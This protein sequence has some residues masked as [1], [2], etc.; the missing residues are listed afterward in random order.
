MGK[1]IVTISETARQQLTKHYKS[2]DK[3]FIK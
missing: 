3:V 1:Y 2:S